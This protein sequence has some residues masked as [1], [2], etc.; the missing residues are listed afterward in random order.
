MLLSYRY[1]TG[2]FRECS[3]NASANPKQAACGRGVEPCFS[4][5][6]DQQPL[7]IAGKLHSVFE[8][9]LGTNRS[10][11]LQD[12][13]R[14]RFH[15]ERQGEEW[16]QLIKVTRFDGPP[17]HCFLDGRSPDNRG[18]RLNESVASPKAAQVF[19]DG[20]CTLKLM[21]RQRF[22]ESDPVEE[23]LRIAM[24]NQGDS[25]SGLRQ[26]LLAS[27]SELG[28]SEEA[29]LAAQRQWEEQ[30]QNQELLEEYRS[31]L[32]RELLTHAGIYLV[33]N[34]ILVLISRITSPHY[35]WA[36][37]PILGWGI[38]F[39]CHTVVSMIQLSNPGGKEFEQWQLR[40]EV[41]ED[42]TDALGRRVY[43]VGIHVHTTPK[44]PLSPKLPSDNT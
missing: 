31:H 44:V 41:N 35:F 17:F 37:W 2:I 15:R 21:A 11:G 14:L 26:R 28:I 33:I 13:T 40:R 12:R 20:A 18:D 4:I 38:G 19:R 27:A 6:A 16:Q 8:V 10:G 1:K 25:E 5:A 34:L 22:R 30:H 43:G 7:S 23:I 36:I 39:G 32:K 9:P 29:V 42:E 3:I 24:Q